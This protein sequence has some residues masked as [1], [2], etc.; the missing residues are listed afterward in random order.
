M[1]NTAIKLD[2]SYDVEAHDLVA[3]YSIFLIN[4]GTKKH[5]SP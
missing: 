5:D 2:S 4:V 3:H 1:Y